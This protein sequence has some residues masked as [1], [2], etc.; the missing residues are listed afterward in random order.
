MFWLNRDLSYRKKYR[1]FSIPWSL[2]SIHFR[3]EKKINQGPSW[4][5]LLSVMTVNVHENNILVYIY[6]MNGKGAYTPRYVHVQPN[7]FPRKLNV[8]NNH[9][10]AYYYTI[11]YTLALGFWWDI[12]IKR[13]CFFFLVFFR[14]SLNGR[15][16]KVRICRKSST[17]TDGMPA[18]VCIHFDK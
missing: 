9:L 13:C 4:Y 15:R 2:P 3:K 17:T 1:Q 12:T 18:C 8:R 11:K 5:I 10:H 6:Y 16:R 7:L 14:I